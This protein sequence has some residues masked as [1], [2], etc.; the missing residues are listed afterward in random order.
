M[1]RHR[2]YNGVAWGD[3]LNGK[4]FDGRYSSIWIRVVLVVLLGWGLLGTAPAFAQ[5]KFETA[6][7]TNDRIQQL[8][9]AFQSRKSDYLIGGG[10]LLHVVS[11]RTKT[12]GAAAD[13]WL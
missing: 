8:A 7:D 10:D 2:R 3:L 5:E 1:V 6:R 12:G 9:S 13:Q 4:S 11:T